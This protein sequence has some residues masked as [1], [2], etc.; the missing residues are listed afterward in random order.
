[1]EAYLQWGSGETSVKQFPEGE[2]RLSG[3]SEGDR[4]RVNIAGCPELCNNRFG[5][6]LY[7]YSR[8]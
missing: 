6:T 8:I 1:M 7:L 5:W 3:V 4:I 2:M